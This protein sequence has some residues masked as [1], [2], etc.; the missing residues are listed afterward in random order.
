[1]VDQEL[2]DLLVCPLGKAPLNHEGDKLTCTKCGLV[3][4]IEDD[5]PVM[6]VEEATMP[7]GIEKVEDL[8][9]YTAKV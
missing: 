4:K 2:L 9:C 7:D 8:A 5:I 3:Y 1:M 6:L